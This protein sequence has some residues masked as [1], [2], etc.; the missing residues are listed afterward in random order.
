[1]REISTSW[2]GLETLAAKSLEAV[3]IA[4]LAQFYV[5]DGLAGRERCVPAAVGLNTYCVSESRSLRHATQR[6]ARAYGRDGRKR[7]S[8]DSGD[9]RA[10]GDR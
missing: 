4:C 6:V 5:R 1:M 7:G 10:Q 3:R 9:Q 8:P 2:L